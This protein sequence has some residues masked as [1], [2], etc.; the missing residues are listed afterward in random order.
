MHTLNLTTLGMH[1]VFHI[2]RA[3][4]KQGKYYIVHFKILFALDGKSSEFNETDW[5]RQNRIAYFLQ[6]WNLVKVIN[7]IAT[8]DMEDSYKIK[9]I[10]SLFFQSFGSTRKR[11]RY[12]TV[13][14]T[15]RNLD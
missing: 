3:S 15:Y 7:P 4:E 2:R 1:Q 5:K 6:E 12:S 13:Q 8:E 14:E 9:I 11:K 10:K